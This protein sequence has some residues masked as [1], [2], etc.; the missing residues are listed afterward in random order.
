[1]NAREHAEAEKARRANLD[2]RQPVVRPAHDE[3]HYDAARH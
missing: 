2:K 1:M 3:H